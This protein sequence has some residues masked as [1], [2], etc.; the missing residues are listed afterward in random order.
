M[1]KE[2]LNIEH[3][4]ELGEEYAKN[5]KELYKL[6]STYNAYSILLLKIKAEYEGRKANLKRY[7]FDANCY[8]DQ[9]ACLFSLFSS[10]ECLMGVDL[11]WKDNKDALFLIDQD[12]LL[13]I[14]SHHIIVASS[15]GSLS[16]VDYKLLSINECVG[17]V[18]N[19]SIYCGDPYY[20]DRHFEDRDAFG[21]FY[22]DGLITPSYVLDEQLMAYDNMDIREILRPQSVD[23]IYEKMTKAKDIKVKK[24][25]LTK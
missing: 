13:R 12:T 1:R 7:Y 9:I 3:R 19:Q 21:L 5:T 23:Q 11:K 6:L 18:Y 4:I 14:N 2:L 8:D 22:N 24:L 25:T 15:I 10:D 16:D 20:C 17:K